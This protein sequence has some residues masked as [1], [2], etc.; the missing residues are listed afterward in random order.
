MPA[1]TLSLRLY[2][3]NERHVNLKALKGK[4]VQKSRILWVRS[5]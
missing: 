5:T 4:T 2:N 3:V 1:S